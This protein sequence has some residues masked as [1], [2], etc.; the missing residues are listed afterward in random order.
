M[1]LILYRC[2]S[3][4]SSNDSSDSSAASPPAVSRNRNARSFLCRAL[5]ARGSSGPAYAGSGR[6]SPALC[7]PRSRRCESVCAARTPGPSVFPNK[8]PDPS[9]SSASCSRARA[10]TD[11]LPPTSQ[12]QRH[13]DPDTRR[14][15]RSRPNKGDI[16]SQ[17]WNRPPGPGVADAAGSPR[18][19]SSPERICRRKRRFLERKQVL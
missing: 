6:R 7:R 15:V 2:K 5:G 13:L 17:R 14:L 8:S 11:P 4:R 19:I 12:Q 1:P 10:R 9:G 3:N 18:A 16:L